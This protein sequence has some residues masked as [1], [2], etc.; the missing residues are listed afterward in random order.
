[1]AK[2]QV[3]TS[4][5][6]NYLKNKHFM[7]N[8]KEYFKQYYIEHKE[9][10]F[11]SYKKRFKP[12]EQE[13]ITNIDGEEWRDIKGLEGKYQV[14]NK[15]RIKSFINY[16]PILLVLNPNRAGYLSVIVGGKGKQVHRLVAEAF[17]PNP[18]GYDVVHHINHNKTDNRVENLVWADR[19]EHQSMH[20]MERLPKPVDQINPETGE[21]VASYPS[22]KE[23]VRQTGFGQTNISECCNG[24]RTTHKGFKW[25][26]V[27][28]S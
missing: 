27:K 24:K 5:K 4:V 6:G 12:K 23:A 19:R 9:D 17:I 21:I 13:E 25:R 15:G 1:M 7:K 28:V 16:N 2:P 3:L 20:N 8:R 18:N 14:S 10:Y 11:K 22:V 26:Y